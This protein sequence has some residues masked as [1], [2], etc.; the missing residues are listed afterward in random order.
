MNVSVM[1]VSGGEVRWVLV[2]GVCVRKKRV[3]AWIVCVVSLS[4]FVN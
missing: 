3:L 4:G 2:N 1:C